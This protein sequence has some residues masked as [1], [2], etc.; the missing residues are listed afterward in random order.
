MEQLQKM[1]ATAFFVFALIA[2]AFPVSALQQIP[3]AFYGTAAIDGIPAPVGTIVTLI[4]TDGIEC[5][6]Q[7]ITRPGEFG[8]IY[9][10]GDD[11]QTAFVEGPKKRETILIFVNGLTAG[12]AT[13]QDAGINRLELQAFHAKTELLNLES[14]RMPS[15]YLIIGAGLLLAVSSYVYVR[16]GAEL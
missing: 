12:N 10:R 11:L 15:I 7:E 4:S 1:C 3:P 8:T 6:T 9:C 16:R 14:T 13:W 5:G 2:V